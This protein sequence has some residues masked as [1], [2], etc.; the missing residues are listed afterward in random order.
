MLEILWQDSRFIEEDAVP[1]DA[2]VVGQTWKHPSKNGGPDRRFANNR[3]LPIWLYES[4]HL[5]SRNGLNELLQVSSHGRA[6]P[7]SEAARRLVTTIGMQDN[8]PPLPSL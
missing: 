6:Q 4:I 3:Q 2:L 8:S 5:R 7:L 1:R